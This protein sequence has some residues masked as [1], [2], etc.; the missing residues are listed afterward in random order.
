MQKKGSKNEV[1]SVFFLQ[2][3]FRLRAVCATSPDPMVIWDTRNLWRP[4]GFREERI[5]QQS[6]SAG[7]RRHSREPVNKERKNACLLKECDLSRCGGF[8]FA[9]SAGGC[10]GSMGW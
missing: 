8:S 5:M 9:V 10:V 1:V 2:P 6:K 4:A 7:I 3:Q